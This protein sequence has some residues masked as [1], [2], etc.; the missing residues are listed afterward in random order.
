MTRHLPVPT[1]NWTLPKIGFC[2]VKTYTTTPGFLNFEQE[3][4]QW[5]MEGTMN[6]EL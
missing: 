2:L 4:N 5:E 3:V 1:P 6:D